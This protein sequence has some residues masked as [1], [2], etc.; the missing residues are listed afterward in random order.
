MSGVQTEIQKKK[1]EMKILHRNLPTR[2]YM[3]SLGASTLRQK[4]GKSF[5]VFG[6]GFQTWEKK[7]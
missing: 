5:G 6:G 3:R 4:V 1:S 2:M 7:V